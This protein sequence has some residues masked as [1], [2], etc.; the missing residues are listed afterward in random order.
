MPGPDDKKTPETSIAPAAPQSLHSELTSSMGMLGE[1]GEARATDIE[2]LHN[3]YQTELKSLG[4]PPKRELDDPLKAFSSL[5]G[6]I[7]VVGSMLTKR[8]L[9]AGL[10]A[11]AAAQKAQAVGNQQEYENK[12]KEWDT[13]Y[14][15]ISAAQ[16]ARAAEL[17]AVMRNDQL[18][19][20]QK[21]ARYRM[22]MMDSN[23]AMRGQMHNDSVLNRMVNMQIAAGNHLSALVDRTGVH[24]DSVLLNVAKDRNLSDSNRAILAERVHGLVENWAEQR[25]IN[26]NLQPPG[27][28]EVYRAADDLTRQPKGAA[29]TAQTDIATAQQLVSLLNNKDPK[30]SITLP[31]GE[32]IT[33]AD[34]KEAH[35][36]KDPTALP[37][38]QRTVYDLLKR[39]GEARGGAPT[40]TGVAKSDTAQADAI[41]HAKKLL[42]QGHT[43]ADII[44]AAKSAGFT[45]SESD[46]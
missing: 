19:E 30:A 33:V 22:L 40:N 15:F 23:N 12:M 6:I 38:L 35:D 8:P 2:A 39:G 43:K 36:S 26:P 1:K 7:G 21:N 5:G 25:R 31:S 3:Q 14:R 11:I 34:V 27:L 20:N 28:T 9:T 10:T 4:E 45:I 42:S 37:L 46:F 18:T 17:Q 24:L 44:A 32:K 29:A 41:A 16:Q 13:H